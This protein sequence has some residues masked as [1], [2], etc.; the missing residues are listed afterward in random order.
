MYNLVDFLADLVKNLYV[1]IYVFIIFTKTENDQKPTKFFNLK[2][3][4]IWDEK[5]YNK[6]TKKI[7]LALI[8]ARNLSMKKG[9]YF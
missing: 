9:L 5:L 2:W 1:F 3:N 4:N 8:I 7:I 6:G